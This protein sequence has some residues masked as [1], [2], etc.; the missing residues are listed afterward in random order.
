M[1]PL[2]FERDEAMLLMMSPSGH[3]ECQRGERWCLE[4]LIE[5]GYVTDAFGF[6]WK[7]WIE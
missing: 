1:R 2:K 6:K 5:N 4:Q 7:A 3:M